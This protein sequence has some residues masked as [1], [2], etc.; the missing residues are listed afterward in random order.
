M[1]TTEKRG[2]GRRGEDDPTSSGPSYPGVF[3]PLLSSPFPP[4]SLGPYAPS[5]TARRRY[6]S[7]VRKV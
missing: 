6:F 4:F 3:F 5:N 2:E 7:G 1:V